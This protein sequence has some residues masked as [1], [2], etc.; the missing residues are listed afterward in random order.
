MRAYVDEHIDDAIVES[1]RRADSDVVRAVDQH[2]RTTQDE[3]H[4][5]EAA[6]EDRVLI[7][8]DEDFLRLHAQY[9][10]DGR[11]HAGIVYWPQKKRLGIGFASQSIL[12][13][14]RDIPEE[15]RRN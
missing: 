12:R 10:S 14:L 4:L 7:T 3:I 11:E 15:H 9:L 8:R 5:A 6:R 1:L 2:P 13:F